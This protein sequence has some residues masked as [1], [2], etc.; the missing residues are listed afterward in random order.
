MP[1]AQDTPIRSPGRHLGLVGPTTSGK[2]D[3]SIALALM[4]IEEGV[5]TE[6]VSCDSMQVYRGMD[7]GTAKPTI[8]ER[9]GIRHHMIDVVDPTSEFNL[10]SFISGVN[11]ALDAVEQRGA[12]AIL[13]GGTGLYFRGVVD[14]FSPPPHFPEIVA[15]LEGEIST[16]EL[17]RRL[18]DVD[19]VALKRIPP[20]NRRRIVRALEVTIGTGSPFSSFG[21]NLDE[22]PETPFVL[23]GLWPTREAITSR[24]AQRYESQMESG[25]L[26]EAQRL[27]DLG[28]D[29]SRTAAKALGYRELM[30]Y[31][32]GESTL[33]RALET[34]RVRTRK[35]AVRQQRWFRRDS[36]IEWFDP[37]SDAADTHIV[38]GRINQLWLKR[39]SEAVGS[40][41]TV[42]TGKQRH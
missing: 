15:E 18:D 32:R 20:G 8:S 13:A 26:S 30:E 36:R 33:E 35:F 34:A 31:L 14:G 22:L 27:A 9:R 29:L 19:P 2:T 11:T 17:T 25:L 1:S 23:T 24:I 40:V 39:A 16:D 3:V 10:P 12:T 28:D 4:R 42:E 41:A 6:I 5:P 7:V 37:P 21:T 38:A